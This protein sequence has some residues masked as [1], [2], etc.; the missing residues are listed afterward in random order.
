MNESLLE[1]F[2]G[3]E[4]DISQ[5]KGPFVLFALFAREDLPDRWDLIVSA[6]WAD[7]SQAGVQ[8]FV[9]EIQK[10][11]GAAVLTELSRIVV[12]PPSEAAVQA[13]NHAINVQH[14]RAEVRNSDFFGLPINHA[15]IITS[16][17]LS[18]APAAQ[19]SNER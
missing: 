2:A 15:W 3:L 13:I 16:Q 9:S 11:I 17:S 14:G 5:A 6:P 19:P 12:V 7:A 8:Y 10:K 4:R 18:G 1:R